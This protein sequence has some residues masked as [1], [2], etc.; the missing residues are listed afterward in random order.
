MD[1]LLIVFA[2][3]PIP[4]LAKTRLF[5]HLSFEEAAELQR[6]FLADMAD[7]ALSSPHF[8]SCLAYTPPGTLGVFKEIYGERFLYHEQGAGDLGERMSRSFDHGFNAGAK[9]VAVVGTD[10]P[11]MPA[12]YLCAA[13]R[14]LDGADIVLGP[15]S[16]GGYYLVA[17]KEPA[18]EIFGRMDWSGPDVLGVTA[19]RALALGLKAD[20]LPKLDDVDTFED[21]KGLTN[22]PL[23]PHTDRLISS[24][25]HRLKEHLD[26]LL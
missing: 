16:D 13:F 15:A 4:G 14:L 7:K 17:L 21:L 20:Y 3:A 22:S 12:C 26:W 9:R 25:G 1:N 2:K 5:P 23:P 8:S 18:P 10:V 11:T 24:I 6:A 19:D